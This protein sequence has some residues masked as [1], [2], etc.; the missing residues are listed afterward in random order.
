MF[1][2]YNL[3]KPVII[4]GYFSD[5]GDEFNSICAK[6]S[7][8]HIDCDLYEATKDALHL[9]LDKIQD[10]TIILFDDWFNFKASPD[11]GEQK[12][13]HEFLKENPRITAIEYKKYA[14][15]CNSFILKVEDSK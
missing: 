7:V 14:T 13:F 1:E 12:A 3:N 6:V 11:K 5:V 2:Y 9:V 4:K 15:F 10:G 8:I